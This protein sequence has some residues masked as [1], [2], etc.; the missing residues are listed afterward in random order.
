MVLLKFIN[1]DSFEWKIN[2]KNW[3]K[4]AFKKDDM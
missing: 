3:E 2:V 1:N 4:N